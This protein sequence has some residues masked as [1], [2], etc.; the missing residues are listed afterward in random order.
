MDNHGLDASNLTPEQNECA[1]THYAFVCSSAKTLLEALE[2]HAPHF[3][4]DCIV[5]DER[6]SLM[7]ASTILALASA[8][9]AAKLD[10]VI[11]TIHGD[12]RASQLVKTTGT[13]ETA[14]AIMDWVEYRLPG[15]VDIVHRSAHGRIKQGVVSQALAEL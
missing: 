11:S 3:V 14:D 1:D 12:M 6:H 8:T 5:R 13:D 7:L 2:S 9:L 4:C 10:P 15:S